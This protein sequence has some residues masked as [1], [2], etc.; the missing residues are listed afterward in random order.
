LIDVLLTIEPDD[1]YGVLFRGSGRVLGGTAV[2]A[3]IADLDRAIELDPESPD[4]RFVVADAYTY[5]ASPDVTRAFTEATQA[6]AGG[7]DTPRVRAILAAAQLASGDHRAAGAHFAR[8]LE[9]VTA[10]LRTTQPLEAGG[11]LALRLT[12]GRVYEVPL[13]ATSGTTISIMTAG[14]DVTDSIAVLLD[15]DGTPVT[16]GDD[17]TGSFAAIAWETAVTGVYRLRVASFEAVET[18]TLEV[19]RD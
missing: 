2:A 11:S 14:T 16:G 17:E 10:D 9:L 1:V 19:T 8:H 3:G 13:P 12:P 7:L 5:G 4:V 15:P 6:L 18:G